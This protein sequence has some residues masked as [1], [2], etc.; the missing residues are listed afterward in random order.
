MAAEKDALSSCVIFPALL[1][2]LVQRLDWTR[3]PK[4]GRTR[5]SLAPGP[6]HHCTNRSSPPWWLLLLL[7]GQLLYVCLVLAFSFYIHFLVARFFFV[8][9]FIRYR[10]KGPTHAWTHVVH[11][12]PEGPALYQCLSCHVVSYAGKKAMARQRNTRRP[13]KLFSAECVC[14]LEAHQGKFPL[15]A[16]AFREMLYGS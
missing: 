7:L 4:G 10:G 3:N 9:C 1:F 6:G 12:R 11:P 2:P 13:R 5:T 8:S 14:V 15:K 16:A